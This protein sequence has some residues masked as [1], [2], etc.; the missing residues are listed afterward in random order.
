MLAT[1][2]ATPQA[3]R[4]VEAEESDGRFWIHESAAASPGREGQCGLLLHVRQREEQKL[5]RCGCLGD[6]A[7]AIADTHDPSPGRE[8]VGQFAICRWALAGE[9]DG[10][11]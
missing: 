9:F 3:G 4:D 11:R 10:V 2:R 8:R 5:V 1:E 7:G 6:G